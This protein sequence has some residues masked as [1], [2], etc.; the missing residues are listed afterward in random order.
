MN[1]KDDKQLDRLGAIVTQAGGISDD[2]LQKID[3]APF[4]RTRLRTAIESERRRR[5]E[6]QIGWLGRIGVATR[7]IAMMAIVTIAAVVSFW[8]SRPTS[9]A[10]GS[11]E[12]QNDVARVVIG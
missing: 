4:L 8:F 6:Q 10:P 3:S 1:G 7:A 2:D 11:S 12:K 5:S 9:N